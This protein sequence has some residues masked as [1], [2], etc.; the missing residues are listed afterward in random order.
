MHLN[1]HTF[2]ILSITQMFNVKCLIF[3]QTKLHALELSFVFTQN[4]L[5]H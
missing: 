2:R 4:K 5:T 3:Q 1:N